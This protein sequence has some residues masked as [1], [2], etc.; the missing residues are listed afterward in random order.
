MTS[1]HEE[2]QG[3]VAYGNRSGKRFDRLKANQGGGRPNGGNYARIPLKPNSN[4]ANGGRPN[5]PYP[6]ME[7]DRPKVRGAMDLSL[8]LECEKHI[9]EGEPQ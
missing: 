4:L 5:K 8:R 2:V 9:R 3:G 6:N 1:E 7:R